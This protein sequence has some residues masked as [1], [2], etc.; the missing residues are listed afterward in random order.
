MKR[1]FLLVAIS[2]LTMFFMQ[3]CG[4]QAQETIK[5]AKE[6]VTEAVDEVVAVFDI[7]EDMGKQPWVFDIEEATIAG[8]NYRMAIWTGDYMQLVL[9]SLKPGETIDLEVHGDHDQFMRIEQGTAR[10]L[11]GKTKDNLT[12]DEKAKDDFAIMIPAGYWHK[13]INE[14]DTDLKL[15]TIYAPAEHPFGTTQKEKEVHLEVLE[16]E[17]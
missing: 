4:E 6:E 14:G 5:E 7:T 3:S 12:F 11:M 15:Y 13:I 9:M 1:V 17:Y 10:V 16:T 2:F 8:D